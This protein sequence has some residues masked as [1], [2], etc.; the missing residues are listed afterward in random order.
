MDADLQ[1]ILTQARWAPSADN[2]Q[3][4]RFQVIADRVVILWYA[5]SPDMGIFCLDHYTGHLAMGALLET[6]AIA[7]SVKGFDITYTVEPER[8]GCPFGLRVSLIPGKGA[9]SPL[10]AY[11]TTRSTQRRLLRK[12]LLTNEQR[13][14]LEKSVGELYTLIWLASPRDK[15]RM[16]GLLSL[17][18]KVR[19]LAPETFKVHRD[20]IAWGAHDSEDRIPSLA[21]GADPVL[22]RVMAWAL[23]SQT[24]VAWLNRFWGH[25]LPRLEMDYLPARACAAHFLI[26]HQSNSDALDARIEHGRALQRFWLT[27][28]SLGLQVQPEMA[29]PVFCRYVRS[30]TVFTSHKQAGSLMGRICSDF[31]GWLGR[32]EWQHTVFMGRLGNGLQPKGRSLRKPLAAFLR[33]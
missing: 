24:R 4:W 17:T 33:P 29:A 14:A 10:A 26:V 16:A 22:R 11:I 9:A 21:I 12:D 2:T 5:P 32:E 27:A 25:W 20:T 19:L 30:G 13:Q 31:S 15:R 7:A 6:L 1:E 23:R 28:T 8:E 18:G 3:P